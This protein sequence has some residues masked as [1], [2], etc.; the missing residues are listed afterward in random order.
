MALPQCTCTLTAVD[1]TGANEGNVEFSVQ[2]VRGTKVAGRSVSRAIITAT[3]HA[4][5]GLLT[6]TLIRTARY[7]IWRS[8]DPSAA[9]PFTVPDASTYDIPEVLGQP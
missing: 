7:R 9:R 5:T 6:F 8:S 4:V 3:S 1:P 2:V